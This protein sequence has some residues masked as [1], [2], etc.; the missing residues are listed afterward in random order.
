[1]AERDIQKLRREMFW[2]RIFSTGLGI[3]LGGVFGLIVAAVGGLFAHFMGW[4]TDESAADINIIWMIIPIAIGAVVLGIRG[5]IEG[6]TTD[7]QL[8]RIKLSRSRRGN[9]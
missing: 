2:G 8:E 3:I 5:W 4:L 9:N 7:A 1:M 6:E